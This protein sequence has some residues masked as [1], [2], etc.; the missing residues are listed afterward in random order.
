VA[1][2]ASGYGFVAEQSALQTRNR[3]GKQLLNVGKSRALALLPVPDQAGARVALA[4][5]AGYL[6]VLDI[7]E[8]PRLARGKGVKLAGIPAK[9]RAAGEQVVAAAVLAEG[10]SLR[11]DSGQ[12]HKNLSGQELEEYLTDRAKRGR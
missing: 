12:R 1:M 3:A 9:A 8:L 11:I 4:T 10:E 7:A 5:S 6:L 2:S